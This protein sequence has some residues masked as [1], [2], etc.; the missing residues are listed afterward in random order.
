LRAEKDRELRDEAISTRRKSVTD[1][2]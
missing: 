2:T 1:V